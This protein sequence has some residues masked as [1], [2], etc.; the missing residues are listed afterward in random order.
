MKDSE[1]IDFESR[2]HTYCTGSSRP[3]RIAHVDGADASA[4]NVCCIW[5]GSYPL[6]DYKG[7]GAAVCNEQWQSPR[8][9]G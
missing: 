3:E 6:A 8:S 4:D 1:Y 7:N 5:T 2:E 9:R